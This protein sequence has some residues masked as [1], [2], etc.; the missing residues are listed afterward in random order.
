MDLTR[1]FFL[2]STGAL[3]AYLGVSPLVL[4][5]GRAAGRL[6]PVQVTKGKTLVVIF[7]RGGADGLNLVIPFGDPHYK[8]LRPGIGIAPPSPEEGAALDLDGFFGLHPGLGGLKPHFDSGLA[9]A[10]HAV[11]YA[12]NTRSHFEEQDV[13]ETGVVGNTV[14]SD[15]WLNRHLATSTGHGPIRAVSIGDSLPRIMQGDA[16]AFALRGLYD[17]SMPAPDGVDPRAMAAALEHAYKARPAEHASAAQDLLAEAAGSTLEAV[18]ELR[19]LA[20][21]PYENQQM[22]PNSDLGMKLRQ[23]AQLIKADLGLEV[24]EVDLNGWDTH[25]SQG[26]GAGGQFGAL[27]GQLGEAL[28]AFARDLGDRMDD[29]LVMTLTDFGRTAA[30]NGSGGTDHGWANCMLFLG[31]AVAKAN[32]KADTGGTPVPLGADTGGTPVPRGSGSGRKV[33]TN[34]PGLAPDQLHEGRDLL[35]TTDFRDVL[36]EIVRVHLGNGNLEAVLPGHAFK[37]V[38]L[39]A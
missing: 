28:G 33:V 2:K 12:K 27:A 5:A 8:G 25:A 31:G 34:W 18:Q 16:P 23:V 9:V 7:L 13:W 37:P 24:V 14:N 17:L 38:G 6:A 36:A 1:R 30:E 29:V 39:V 32:K 15:G 22:Y 19:A 10:A 35:H 11:G 4:G 26:E 20:A 3:A 21:K